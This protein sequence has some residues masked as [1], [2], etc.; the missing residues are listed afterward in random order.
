MTKSRVSFSQHGVC[1]VS[2]WDWSS[3]RISDVI[4]F[5]NNWT[6]HG[7]I[8]TRQIVHRSD[9]RYSKKNKIN[10]VWRVSP[11]MALFA[12]N[13][14]DRIFINGLV[15]LW[16]VRFRSLAE[17]KKLLG[18]TRNMLPI[19]YVPLLLAVTYSQIQ[20]R[21]LLS[22]PNSLK[23]HSCSRFSHF[24]V[25][26]W[27]TYKLTWIALRWSTMI[28]IYTKSHFGRML[29]SGHTYTQPTECITRPLLPRTINT[30]I[31]FKI[32]AISET[33]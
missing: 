11:D 1:L 15:V 13:S 33:V 2:C 7:F 24:N 28:N 19:F 12:L 8:E 10:D 27:L 29:L 22:S 31:L 16:C 32:N 23:C 20:I 14:H 25:W 6:V 30:L 21:L 5:V 17:N 18:R 26:P 9:G 3:G 4:I